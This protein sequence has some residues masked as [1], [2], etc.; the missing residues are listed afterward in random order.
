VEVKR[1]RN[2]SSSACFAA[3]SHHR[4]GDVHYRLSLYLL[5]WIIWLPRGKDV[6]FVSSNSPSKSEYMTTSIWPHLS[7][8]SVTLNWPEK[9][10]W[11]TWSLSV[12]VFR[13]FAR[14]REHTPIVLIFRPFRPVMRFRFFPAFKERGKG[15]PGRW[16]HSGEICCPRSSLHLR[17]ADALAG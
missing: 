17:S 13:H 1:S 11:K 3:C 8:R 2:C 14:S 16:R 10:E 12:R 4:T 6:L 5:L 9:E 15:N 7:H